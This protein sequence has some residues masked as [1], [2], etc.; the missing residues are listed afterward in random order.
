MQRK[1]L[2]VFTGAL[3]LGVIFLWQ[4]LATDTEAFT[5][6]TET[7]LDVTYRCERLDT[8]PATLANAGAAHQSFLPVISELA[9]MQ[10][11]EM[12]AVMQPSRESAA[13]VPELEQAI[14]DGEARFEAAIQDLRNNFGCRY[15]GSSKP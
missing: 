9:R 2:F 10:A 8:P 6:P 11:A 12:Q 13:I 4:L 14:S 15:M 1:T 7:G 5:F 3:S